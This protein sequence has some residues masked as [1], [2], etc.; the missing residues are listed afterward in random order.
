MSLTLFARPLLARLSGTTRFGEAH[1]A[2][3]HLSS[4]H[5]ADDYR[6][7]RRL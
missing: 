7:N 1:N 2:G 3:K 5:L 4:G 6:N